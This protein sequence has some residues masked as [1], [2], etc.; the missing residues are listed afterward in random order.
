MKYV[1]AYPYIDNIT[2][3][4]AKALRSNL[5][6]DAGLDLIKDVCFPVNVSMFDLVNA[7]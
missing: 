1:I 4:L 6:N 2:F 5:K 7:Y 3:A